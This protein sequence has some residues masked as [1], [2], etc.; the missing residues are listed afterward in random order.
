MFKLSMKRRFRV[1]IILVSSLLGNVNVMQY[2]WVEI[3]IDRNRKFEHDGV[4][5]RTTVRRGAVQRETNKFL[6]REN[7]FTTFSEPALSFSRNVAK[8]INIT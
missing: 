4:L 8:F 6:T 1:I 2:I 7:R 5:Q 3:K